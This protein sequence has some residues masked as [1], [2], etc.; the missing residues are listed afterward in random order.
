MRM[1]CTI[2]SSPWTCTTPTTQM[3]HW[4][5]LLAGAPAPPWRTRFFSPR[6]SHRS[7]VLPVPFLR[8]RSVTAGCPRRTPQA[9][10]YH[11][12][13]A[14]LVALAR[15]QQL[16]AASKLH[17]ASAD[18]SMGWQQVAADLSPTPPV[19]PHMHISKRLRRAPRATRSDGS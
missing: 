8:L 15:G 6:S 10:R 14:Q 3:K 11:A 5:C 1:A 12:C 7:A 17:L 18:T 2:R 4:P 9:L 16:L 19:V 13:G